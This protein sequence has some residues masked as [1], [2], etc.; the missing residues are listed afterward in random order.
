MKD[1][2]NVKE[3]VAAKPDF[4]GFIFYPRSAR[5][6]GAKPDSSIFNN[7]PSGITRV[8][9]FV[10]ETADKI[11]ELAHI[12]GL[13][14][15]QLHGDE[16]PE[17]CSNLRSSGLKII[18][19]FKASWSFDFKQTIP[20]ISACDYFLFDTLTETP[21]GSGMKFNWNILNSYNLEKPFF[22]SGGIGPGDYGII[23]TIENRGLFAVDI[24]SCFE[25]SPG[26]KDVKMVKTFIDRLKISSL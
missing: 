18:K 19:V 26:I 7:I 24:N 23:K 15:L 5:Y 9:V 13:E 14:M 10:D 2:S 20:Y 1:P 17:F 3:I 22:L 11:L 16:S 12:S 4:M 21:G 25:I 8:G 6:V